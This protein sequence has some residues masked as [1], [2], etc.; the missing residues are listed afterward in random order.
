MQYPYAFNVPLI[1]ELY[2]GPTKLC[3]ALQTVG[4]DVKVKTV[5]K[6]KERDFIPSDGIAALIVL[7]V[8]D[9]REFVL[10]DLLV[11]R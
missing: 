1:M 11:Q 10:T 2:G 7:M 3:R 5:Q 9:K 6:W 4:L 8:K